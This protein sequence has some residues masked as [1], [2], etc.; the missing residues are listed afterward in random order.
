[1][2]EASA[3]YP[4]ETRAVPLTLIR[5]ERML[6]VPGKVLVTPGERVQ[7]TQVVAQAEISGEVRIVNVARSLRV[8]PSRAIRYLKVK[9]G[10]DVTTNTVIATRG[11]LSMSR[12]LSPTNGFVYRIDKN[13]GRVLIK[14]VTRPFQLIAYLQGT[15]ANALPGHGVVIETTGAIIQGT[16]GFG[17]ESYGV[18]HIVANDPNEVLRAK[19]IDVSAHGAIVI[20]G[21]WI[22]ES[23]LSQATQLQVR[24][25][26]A[27]SM[28]GRL[29]N[30]A[31][32]V[33]FPIILTEGLGRI[34]MARPIFKL[35]QSQSGREASISAVTRTRWGI[36]RPEILIPLPADTKPSPV[37]AIG[38]PIALGVRVR[39][40]RGLHQGA[41]GVVSALSDQLT[42][43][44][45]GARVHGAEVDL[46]TIGKTFV[47]FANLEILRS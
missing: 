16:V 33:S 32:N 37:A 36:T 7:P 14:V 23:A 10:D 42:Q 12:I 45:S 34:P 2:S 1:M 41:S 9:E 22:D 4:L 40:V 5:R 35:L 26:I 46:D 24:G 28:D 13:K 38:T 20:G 44:E 25:L 19:S 43:I 6:P 8:A 30:A 27:G 21:A 18:L 39:V 15:V 3:Y 11:A 31:R 29:L 17:D 47:P